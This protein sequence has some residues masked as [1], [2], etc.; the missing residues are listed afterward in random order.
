MLA[1][2][3]RSLPI[4]T[5]SY[6]PPFFYHKRV[7]PEYKPL[8]MQARA[9]RCRDARRGGACSLASVLVTS[10]ATMFSLFTRLSPP[11]RAVASAKVEASRVGGSLVTSS[12]LLQAFETRWPPGFLAPTLVTNASPV[13]KLAVESS[14]LLCRAS[15]ALDFLLL[16]SSLAR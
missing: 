3:T 9:Q 11:C 4:I 15:R 16:P 10:T 6:P 2:E 8:T 7:I 13:G 5:R 1:F 12:E 14:D